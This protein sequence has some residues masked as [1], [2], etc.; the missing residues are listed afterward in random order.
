MPTTKLDR[1]GRIVIP[2]PIRDGLGLKAGAEVTITEE[3]ETIVLSPTEP[4]SLVKLKGHILVYTGEAVGDL[5]DAV[6]RSREE[7]I[8]KV[9][10]MDEP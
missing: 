4:P 5:V 8:R 6:R 1:F 10:G 3:G 7:R 2:K 9:S